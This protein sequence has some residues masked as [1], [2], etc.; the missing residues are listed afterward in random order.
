MNV[1][2]TIKVRSNLI[3]NV[4]NIHAKIVLFTGHAKPKVCRSIPL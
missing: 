1:G 3:F 2:Q 4:K